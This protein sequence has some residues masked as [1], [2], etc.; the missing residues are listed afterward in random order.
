MQY[1]TRYN[2]KPRKA[3]EF[4]DWLRKNAEQLAANA[5]TGWKYLGTWCTVYGFGKYDCEDRWELDGYAALGADF[6]NETY[7]QLFLEW[8]EFLNTSR[9]AETC[10]MKSATDIAIPPGF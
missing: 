6:G 10:L 1:I 5:P 8:F 9:D 2:I 3:S 7:Q 4:R